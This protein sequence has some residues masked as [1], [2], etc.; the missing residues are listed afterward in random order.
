MRNTDRKELNKNVLMAGIGMLGIVMMLGLLGALLLMLGKGVT[1]D[2]KS[3]LGY[4]GL[5]LASILLA[6]DI[7]LFISVARF[8]KKDIAY[9]EE[10]KEEKSN[11]NQ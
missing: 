2:I 4:A 6:F 3:I 1:T 7:L 9:E 8:A 10:S 11:E 5:I